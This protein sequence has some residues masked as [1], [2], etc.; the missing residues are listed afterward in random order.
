MGSNLKAAT[1]KALVVLVPSYTAAY[2]TEQ[3]VYVV[4]TLAA[5]GF[6]ASSLD[7]SNRNTSNRVDDDGEDD[8]P[9]DDFGVIDDG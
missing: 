7:L 2:L 9:D 6:F 5:A 3:M 8:G 1:V 4:P